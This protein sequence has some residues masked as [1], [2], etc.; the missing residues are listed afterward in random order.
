MPEEMAAAGNRALEE[1]DASEEL[2]QETV[3][4]YV[5]DMDNIEDNTY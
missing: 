5:E 1:A 2:L 3:D 4:D